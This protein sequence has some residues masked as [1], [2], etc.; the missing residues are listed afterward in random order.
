MSRQPTAKEPDQAQGMM[1]L[2][3]PCHDAL[4]HVRLPAP[5]LS[6]LSSSSVALSLMCCKSS[7][8]RL[9]Q[10]RSA[11]D[12]RDERDRHRQKAE[13]ESDDIGGGERG[14][15]LVYQGVAR[16]GLACCPLRGL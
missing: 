2:V 9:R 4:C 7:R 10:G 12:V 13:V 8:I 3:V 1:V 15:D 6:I 14:R 5:T 16:Q 11:E